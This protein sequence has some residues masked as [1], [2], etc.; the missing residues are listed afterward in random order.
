M[1]IIRLIGKSIAQ[2]A[3]GTSKCCGAANEWKGGVLCCSECGQRQ[4]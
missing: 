1:R 4:S 3:G 2:M